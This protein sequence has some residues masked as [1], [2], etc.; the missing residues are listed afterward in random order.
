MEKQRINIRH[1]FVKRLLALCIFCMLMSGLS[2]LWAASISLTKNQIESLIIQPDPS[3]RLVTDR[4][5]K[6]ILNIPLVSAAEVE[7]RNPDFPN[8]INFKS[9]R[10]TTNY[11][12]GGTKLE[13]WIT[14]ENPGLQNP[15][16]LETFVQNTRCFIPFSDVNIS[17]NP[18]DLFPQLIVVP[19]Q[20]SAP[21]FNLGAL[22]EITGQSNKVLPAG[23]PVTF[24]LYLKYAQRAVSL[25]HNLPENCLF[26]Q[27]R[28]VDYTEIKKSYDENSQNLIDLGTYT[29]TPINAG[30]GTIPVFTSDAYNYSNYKSQTTSVLV[31]MKIGKAKAVEKKA[32]E[33]KQFFND[34]FYIEQSDAS[35]STHE[36]TEEEIE[37]SWKRIQNRK[38]L[39]NLLF[40]S[41]I[42]IT[43]LL[44]VSLLWKRRWKLALISLGFTL[45]LILS[46]GIFLNKD[47]RVFT[48]T[49]LFSI[50]EENAKSNVPLEKGTVVLV[51]EETGD[52]LYVKSN[53]TGGWAKKGDFYGHE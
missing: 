48:G 38:K 31:E 45:V 21:Y 29:W 46:K 42:F 3:E 10:K 12:T 11:S 44:A 14:F 5:I 32:S 2:P 39:L 13:I 53:S 33:S 22:G 7:V 24:N 26:T 49:V 4:E 41:L 16:K 37:L 28:T 17:A 34:G 23:T 9:F 6:F 30:T 43:V 40:L 20:K 19:S 27:D 1:R 47:R 36:I 18:K 35:E 50:P 51:E 25:N 15:G 8:G 52:W